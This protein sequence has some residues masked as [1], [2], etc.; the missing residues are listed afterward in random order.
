MRKPLCTQCK[1]IQCDPVQIKKTTHHS[2]ASESLLITYYKSATVTAD[3]FIRRWLGKYLMRW[4]ISRTPLVIHSEKVDVVLREGWEAC[5]MKR[6]GGFECLLTLPIH[7]QRLGFIK[8]DNFLDYLENIISSYFSLNHQHSIG[9]MQIGTFSSSQFNWMLACH[10]WL[11]L[12]SVL[13]ME[14]CGCV[15]VLSEWSRNGGHTI[16][17]SKSIQCCRESLN[18]TIANNGWH[19]RCP[20][21]H[22]TRKQ[23]RR[24]WINYLW[25]LRR[26]SI[27]LQVARIQTQR[28]HVVVL[29]WDV[30]LCLRVLWTL[31]ES[32]G[33]LV[34]GESWHQKF[35]SSKCHS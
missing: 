2:P 18:L 33:F 32:A 24:V 23:D 9:P 8:L 10:L 11:P 35:V 21:P 5:V 30:S 15:I 25:V 12:V 6:S 7:F 16:V 19:V 1:T 17:Q 4:G 31:N 29:V 34:G 22:L 14:N 26:K 20:L 13:K 28:M 27:S 3:P